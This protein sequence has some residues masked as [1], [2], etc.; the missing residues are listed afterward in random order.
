MV[1]DANGRQINVGD[2]VMHKLEPHSNKVHGTLRS[3]YGNHVHNFGGSAIVEQITDMGFVV[4]RPHHSR[5]I[6]IHCPG[7]LVVIDDTAGGALPPYLV[8]YPFRASQAV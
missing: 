2:R 5:H 7:L 8:P 1:V 6:P 3:G 4:V